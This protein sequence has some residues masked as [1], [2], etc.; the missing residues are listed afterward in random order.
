MISIRKSQKVQ[1]F[2][3]REPLPKKS[4]TSTLVSVFAK[5]IQTLILE[6]VRREVMWEILGYIPIVIGYLSRGNMKLM[7]QK[8][9]NLGN[10]KPRPCYV[11]GL[12]FLGIVF[13]RIPSGTWDFAKGRA[14]YTIARFI[15]NLPVG[16]RYVASIWFVLLDGSAGCRTILSARDFRKLRFYIC[17]RF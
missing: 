9:S 12:I 14:I 5:Y 4:Y 13:R 11:I 16:F 2:G 15:F 10:Q 1:G 8:L 6:W 17:H 3:G 7:C